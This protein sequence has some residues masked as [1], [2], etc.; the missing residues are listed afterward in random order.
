MEDSIITCKDDIAFLDKRLSRIDSWKLLDKGN[1]T[2]ITLEAAKII[3][4]SILCYESLHLMEYHVDVK[5]R[6]FIVNVAI[7]NVKLGVL[8]RSIGLNGKRRISNGGVVHKQSSNNK[9]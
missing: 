8:V 4:V 5:K 3:E 9:E 7:D 1:N 2:I 6:K